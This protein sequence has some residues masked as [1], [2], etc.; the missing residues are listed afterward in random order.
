M[1][2][3]PILPTPG[4]SLVPRAKT[5]STSGHGSAEADGRGAI[6]SA[7][8]GTIA[9]QMR[10]GRGGNRTYRIL[11]QGGDSC[12]PG[13]E[14]AG[15]FRAGCQPCTPRESSQLSAALKRAESIGV[16]TAGS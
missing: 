5:T 7:Q 1:K 13:K 10:R 9:A 14:S 12:S 8:T 2:L 3:W 16:D 11:T 4:G 6:T 15:R